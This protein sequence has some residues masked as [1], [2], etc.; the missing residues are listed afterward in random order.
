[1]ARR[2]GT[3]V[4]IAGGGV[5][6]IALA[7][8]LA[9]RG[10]GTIVLE[11]AP[12]P[13]TL[14]RAHAV[15]PRTI[16]ILDAELGIGAQQLRAVAAPKE[17]TREVR[18]VTTMTGH[19]FGAVPYERQDDD[20]L[21]V[22]PAALLNVP[23]PALE[24]LLFD[25]VATEPAVDLRR[26]HRWVGLEREDGAVA[27]I[28]E[29]ATGSYRLASRYLVAADGAGSAVREALGIA[30]SGVEEVA[31][32]VSI[33]F[34]ADLRE[35]VRTRP[36][37]LHWLYGPPR[38]GTLIAHDPG[39][40]WAY[41]IKLPPG[42]VDV[43]QF[44]GDRAVALIRE[45]LGPAAGD[46]AIE[47]L[48]VTPWKMRAEVADRYRAGNV[49]LAG[50]AA[51]RFPPTGGLGLNTGVQDAHNLAWKLAAVLDGWAGDALLDTYGSERSAVATRN[52]AQSLT[53]FAELTALSMLAEAPPESD[54]DALA[55]WLAE[56]GRADAIAAAIERQ[57]PHFDSLAL[58]LGFSYDPG[59]PPIEDVSRFVP[60]AAPG[61][62][63]PHGWLR[64]DGARRSVLDLLDPCAFT[65]L[66]LDD[67]A[68]APDAPLGVP[69]TAV[70][71]RD[72]DP[73]A[74]AWAAA[75][76]LDGAAAVLVRPDGHVLAVAAGPDDLAGLAHA[77]MR[78][79]PK[80]REEGLTW[81]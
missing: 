7:L 21:A 56:P 72:D 53:N 73:E 34:A 43:T 66:L 40:L 9:R 6:G 41:S 78:L 80:P 69:L 19:A 18:F 5:V 37:V 52:A 38:R 24:A 4:T 63:L 44:R 74:Q 8:L 28:V 62:R 59:D 22:T 16:E 68:D 20:V 60:R 13:Q 49:L 25:R 64:I 14:P 30:M 2:E 35:I 45:A 11:Q 81:T 58:Q 79:V 36:G 51:H 55:A 29:T 54:P 61:R 65:L 48:G 32:A 17:L 26:G 15:N 47:V 77:I 71:L 57:R 27:S 46:V 76:G 39:R 67:D 12:E 31:S 3:P 70:R 10:V 1:M 42:R 23:Q 33:T 75:V 50:D